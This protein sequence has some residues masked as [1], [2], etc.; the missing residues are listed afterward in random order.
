MELSKKQ[1]EILE[2][3]APIVFVNAAA[4]AGKTRVLTEKIRQSVEQGK[5]V[6]AFTFTNMAAGEMKSRLGVRNNEN[7]FIGT[8]HS[9]CAQ[10][11]FKAGVEG[12]S[13]YIEKEE[14]DKLFRLVMQNPKCI[15]EIDI[16]ICDEAQ[17]SNKYQL[18]FIF[19]ILMAKEYFIVYDERQSIYRW[20]GA[21][22]DLLRSY[23]ERLK[24]VVYSLNENYRNGRHIL[25]FARPLLSKA[26]LTDDSIAMRKENGKIKLAQFD[27][28][29]IR[30]YIKS[31]GTYKDWAVLVRT[32]EQITMVGEILKKYD[33]PYD[34]FKQGDL[35]KEEL[36]LKMQ[37]NTVKVLTVHSAKGLEWPYCIVIGMRQYDA[38]SCSV[39]Y[40]AATRA[41][42]GLL[43]M[44]APNKKKTETKMMKWGS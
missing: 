44:A 26:H 8:I 3:E 2:L 10:L 31:A 5:K 41:R 14:F 21:K 37:A 13:E 34:T 7:L 25:D 42:D 38:E 24:A 12:V 28:L 36:D 15:P 17:D 23:S 27:G 1:K 32:N 16:C 30:D 35:L 18:M 20:A 19:D 39:A 9:Y 6:V 11:L 40:V 22:P 43:W 4:A 29:M 33:I